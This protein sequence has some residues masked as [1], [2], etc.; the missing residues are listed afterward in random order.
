[1]STP[2]QTSEGLLR[3]L[4]SILT[5][6]LEMRPSLLTMCDKSFGYNPHAHLHIGQSLCCLPPR[7]HRYKLLF[8]FSHMHWKSLKQKKRSPRY[9]G[10]VAQ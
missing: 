1:V 10:W 7:H 3:Q 4:R 8:R 5:Y 2:W 9:I 6:S